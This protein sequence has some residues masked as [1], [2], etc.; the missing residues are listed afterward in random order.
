LK[1]SRL[2]VAGS[3]VTLFLGL[4][5]FLLQDA[6]ISNPDQESLAGVPM[7]SFGS[8]REGRL[9]PKFTLPDLN[10]IRHQV[11]KW[12]GKV[13]VIN[14]WATWCPPCRKEIPE[15]IKLQAKYGEQGLQ[16]VGIAIDEPDSVR[17]FIKAME[18]NYPILVGDSDAI[19]VSKNYGND[20]G[21]LPY[22]AFID[23]NGRIASIKQGE[24]SREEADATIRALL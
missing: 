11:T 4:A 10:G 19:T 17:E 8:D 5:A 20:I 15:F 18:V 22:T 9:R 13:L 16:F 2:T 12:D 21:A 1:K 14:F 3:L 6:L 7:D 24:L 23:R